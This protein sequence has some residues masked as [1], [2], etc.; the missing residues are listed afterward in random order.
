[1]DD[2]PAPSW[3]LHSASIRRSKISWFDLEVVELEEQIAAPPPASMLT[4]ANGPSNGAGTPWPVV[5]SEYLF[6]EFEAEVSDR[7]HR[8]E[9]VKKVKTRF[10]AAFPTVPSTWPPV[11]DWLNVTYPGDT[12]RTRRNRFDTLNS[13]LAFG[14]SPLKILPYNPLEGARLPVA[15]ARRLAPSPWTCSFAFTSG[16]CSTLIAIT[17][18][19]CSGSPWGGVPSSASAS[20]LVMCA[21]RWPGPTAISAGSKSTGPPR[22][23]GP[24]SCPRCWMPWANWPSRCRTWQMMSL[25]SGAGRDQAGIRGSLSGTRGYAISFGS[26][27]LKPAYGR[28]C[29]TPSLATCGTVLPP[30]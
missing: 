2:S 8:L 17:A 9:E 12:G 21:R 29:P 28:K 4:G 7:P 20:P 24:P 15:R 16:P 6:A 5:S 25:S 27:S 18:S 13:T 22:R 10:A 26:C 14:V 30:T 19:G 1:M 11:R 3:A 23:N